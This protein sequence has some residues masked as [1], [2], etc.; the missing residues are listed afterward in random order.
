MLP[1][2]LFTSAGFS[3][4]TSVGLLFNLG[5]YGSLFSLALVLER[6]LYRSPVVAGLA[7]LPLTAVTAVTALLSGRLT[8][9]FGPKTSMLGGL[10]GGLTGTALLAG[11]GDHLGA[12]GLAGLGAIVGLVGLA[13]PAMTGVALTAAG[14]G[15][16][17]LGAAVLNAARQ[18]GGALGVALLGS[19]TLHR[20]AGRQ[21]A[22][23]LPHLLHPMALATIGYLIAVTVTMVTIGRPGRASG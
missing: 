13:M 9:R 8:T 17:G 7:L 19:A 4:A 12:A 14:S 23:A 2:A 18:A 3:G 6:T 10:A 20:V 5:L 15:R 11:F 22:S 1:P 21:P 16:A